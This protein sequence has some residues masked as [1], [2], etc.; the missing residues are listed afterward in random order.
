MGKN[1]LNN[2]NDNN[3]NSYN[4]GFTRKDLITRDLR[5]QHSTFYLKNILAHAYID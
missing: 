4:T 5:L 3:E 1:G 2:N